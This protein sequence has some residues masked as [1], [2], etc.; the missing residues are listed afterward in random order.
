MAGKIFISYRRSETAWAARAL[1]ER[2]WRE[3]PERVFIDIEGLSL[4]TKFNEVIDA[5]LEGCEVM[6]ALIGQTWLAELQKRLEDEDEPDWVRAEQARGFWPADTAC[7]Q[8]LW[9][10]VVGETP[11]HFKGDSQLPGERVSWDDVTQKFLPALNRQL[12]GVAAVLPTEAQ[13]EYACR[14]GTETAYHFGDTI[15]TDQVNYNG[16]HPSPGG[17][18]GEFRKR[19]VPVKAL[20]ANTW[21]LYQMYGNVREWCADARRGYTAEP[22]VEDP[23]GGQDGVFRVLRGGAWSGEAGGRAPR[24]ATRTAA[25]TAATASASGLP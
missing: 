5:H 14:A 24:T 3:F 4:G 13:W 23:D 10:A 7:T 25:T 21:G 22:V 1:F 11:S 8:G 15:D 17:R 20:P 2:L 9:R 6:L 18:Q 19:A 16:N 12:S